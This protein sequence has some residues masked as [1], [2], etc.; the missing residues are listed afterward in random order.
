VVQDAIRASVLP[1]VDP[2]HA[3]QLIVG[4]SSWH[5]KWFDPEHHDAEALLTSCFALLLRGGT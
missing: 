2:A 1:P 5:Y 4:M 3:T